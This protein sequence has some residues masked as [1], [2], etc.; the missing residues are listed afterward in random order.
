LREPQKLSGFTCNIARFLAI[1]HLRQT[2]RI[3]P[4][5]E[6]SS[7]VPDPK[8]NP[9]NK[10]LEEEKTKV[11]RLVLREMTQARDREVLRR[12]YL[13]E[14]DKERICADLGLSS[15][16]FNRVLFR[17]RERFR[18]LYERCRTIQ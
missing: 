16:Q 15:L 12:F 6:P 11:V 4:L 10:L 8:A 2:R 9:L 18:E 13:E 3:Q 17:A 1:G 14:E 7:L 5:E